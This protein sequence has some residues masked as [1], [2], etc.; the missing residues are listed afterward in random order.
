MDDPEQIFEAIRF[1]GDYVNVLRANLTE[2]TIHMS[3]LEVKIANTPAAIAA[4]VPEQ[5]FSNR[6]FCGPETVGGTV[7][8]CRLECGGS[9]FKILPHDDTMMVIQTEGLRLADSAGC[10]D[11][12]RVND[13]MSAPATYVLTATLDCAPWDR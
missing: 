6:T 5:V 4:G 1:S 10:S 2:V 8:T 11:N 12:P 7:D 13:L 3:A 9:K